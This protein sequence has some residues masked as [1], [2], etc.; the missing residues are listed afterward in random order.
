MKKVKQIHIADI[1]DPELD[2]KEVTTDIVIAGIG[3][4]FGVPKKIRLTCCNPEKHSCALNGGS[5]KI[6]IKKND[7]RLLNCYGV[8][9]EKLSPALAPPCAKLEILSRYSLRTFLALPKVR[10]LSAKR[11]DSSG[12]VDEKGREFKGEAIYFIDDVDKKGIDGFVP[13]ASTTYRAVGIAQTEPK[14]QKKVLQVTDLVRIEQPWQSFKLTQELETEFTPFKVLPGTGSVEEKIKQIT[15]DCTNHITHRYGE[16]RETILTAELI[17]MSTPIVLELEG[18]RK[19]GYGQ[20]LIVGDTGEA[21][22]TTIE[23]LLNA[24]ELGALATGSAATRTGLT[25]S[26]DDKVDERRVL[27]WGLLPQNNRGLVVVDEAHKFSWADWSELTD[28]RSTGEVRVDKSIKGRHPAEV[29]QIYLANPAQ[30]HPLSNYYAGIEALH[31]LM[32]LEDLRRFDLVAIA[33]KG[34]NK[35]K[36]YLTLEKDRIKEAQLITPEIWN[37]HFRWAWSLGTGSVMWSEEA[38]NTLVTVAKNLDDRYGAAVDIPLVG[39]DIKDKLAR[40]SQGVAVL[41]HSTQDHQT[42][43]VL[44]EHVEY[45]G[46]LMQAIYD[47]D[48]CRLDEYAAASQSESQ[49]TDKEYADAKKELSQVKSQSMDEGSL[50]ELIG[51]FRRNDVLSLDDLTGLMN[52]G[53]TT[54]RTR[55]GILKKYRFL[56]SGKQ[57]YRRTPRF[58]A[59]L[60]R[61]D[62]DGGKL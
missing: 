34:D 44:K 23:N 28:V 36:E 17:T 13:L 22:T 20:L 58:V 56:R 57:G 62:N 16:H 5:M 24:I 47:H 39:S 21:K 31:G 3:D 7:R 43:Q 49:L 41:V 29:R 45:T 11:D 54:I 42:V 18:E 12:V 38:L 1:T 10:R 26:L 27:R 37:A 8:P 53:R 15:R 48:N 19:P 61:L 6:T 50:D 55:I 46:K 60:R 30:S 59:F 25:Y 14:K 4:T 51:A 33:A 32:R 40:L 2:G 9:D 52:I 35:N